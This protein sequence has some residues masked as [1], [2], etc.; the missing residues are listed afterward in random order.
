MESGSVSFHLPIKPYL[1]KYL[2]KKYGDS[3]VVSRNSWLGTYIIEIL[4]KDYRK[5]NAQLDRK[6]SYEIKVPSSIV[7]RN[8]FDISSTK[9]KKLDEMIR[10]IFVS[11]LSSYIEVSKASGLH[12]KNTAHKSFNKQNAMQA[13][14]QF[15]EFYGIEEGD[16][17]V[18]SLY[19]DY[20]RQKDSDN[21][22]NSKKQKVA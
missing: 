4:D 17:R 11:D 2:L 21:D 20:Q 5:S 7:I 18:E 6:S 15:L 16:L 19:R 13:I 14:Y 10:Y 8:G 12:F 3:F 9:M 1:K 22:A